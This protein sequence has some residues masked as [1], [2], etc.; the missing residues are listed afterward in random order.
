MSLSP[1]ALITGASEGIGLELARVFAAHGHRLALVAR[2]ADRL[3]TLAQEIVAAGGAA[4]I[5]IAADLARP[6][7]IDLVAA[8]IAAAGAQTQFLVNNAGF[9]LNGAFD[10]VD[11]AGQLGMIDLNVR[12]LTALTQRFLPDVKA[13]RGGLLNVASIAAYAPGPGMAVYYASKAYVLSLTEALHEELRGTGVRV[14]ALCPGPVR[15]GFQE[16]AGIDGRAVQGAAVLSARATAE[17]GYEGLMRN[18]RVVVPGAVNKGLVAALA[19]FPHA[20]MLPKIAGRQMRRSAPS[21][22][23][24]RSGS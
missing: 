9:G 13:Q 16:R 19:W 1:V 8:Q 17:A 15:T 24:Q 6:E 11:A 22:A 23:G 2:R 3:A 20:V 7:A 10:A 18:R 21:A 5:A 12:A 4:P 14:S